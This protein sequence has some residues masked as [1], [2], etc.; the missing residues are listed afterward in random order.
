MTTPILLLPTR[1]QP[2]SLHTMQVQIVRIQIR[3]PEY[4]WTTQK[5]FHLLNLLVCSLRAGVFAFREQVQQVPSPLAQAALLDLPGENQGGLGGRGTG[6]GAC[7]F[8]I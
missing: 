4:G 8:A 7:S 6:T 3:V 2:S 5:V 1:L